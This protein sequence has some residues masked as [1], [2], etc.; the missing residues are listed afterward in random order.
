MA[1]IENFC[2]LT[3]QEQEQF[4]ADIVK[5][6][7]DQKLFTKE[8]D[9]EID[10]HFDEYIFANELTGNLDIF[11]RLKEDDRI[12]IA[13]YATWTADEDDLKDLSDA[14]YEEDWGSALLAALD[15]TEVEIDGY[16]LTLDVDTTDSDGVEDIVVD[17]HS[18][19]HGG[20]GHYDYW[21]YQG[22]DDYTYCEVEGTIYE[23]IWATFTLTIEPIS[24]QINLNIHILK[25]E[26]KM[27]LKISH[28]FLFFITKR[29]TFFT[30]YDII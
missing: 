27:R 20:I 1:I 6:I 30:I 4:A 12:E 28:L 19:Q 23:S 21:G 13:R 7:N 22:Y 5:K 11:L 2:E 17:S 10:T 15:R 9:F 3:K 14:E 8:A 16:K 29:L 24:K 25:V 26:K 18:S